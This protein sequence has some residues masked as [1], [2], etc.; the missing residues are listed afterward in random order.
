[1][2]TVS[3]KKAAILSYLAKRKDLSP[4][5]RRALKA[6]MSGKTLKLLK[7]VNA[8]SYAGKVFRSKKRRA[9]ASGAGE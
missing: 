7:Y 2:P 1:M 3:F 5:Q 4:V 9:V 8:D 6:A